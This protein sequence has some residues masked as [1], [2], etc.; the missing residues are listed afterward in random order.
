MYIPLTA[1]H[2]WDDWTEAGNV[3]HAG[4]IKGVPQQGDRLNC[5]HL[6]ESRKRRKILK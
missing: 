1:Q 6:R 4:T 2:S 3:L 5:F